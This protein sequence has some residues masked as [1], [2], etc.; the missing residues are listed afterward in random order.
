MCVPLIKREVVT[1]NG[2]LFTNFKRKSSIDWQI[3]EKESN[4][5]PQLSNTAED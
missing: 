2:R 5:E 4:A 3:C 1:K